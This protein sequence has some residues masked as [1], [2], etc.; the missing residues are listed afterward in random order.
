[1]TLLTEVMQR[2]LDPG[3]AQAARRRAAGEPRP[4][5]A[6]T[7]VVALACGVIVSIAV[8]Q[9]RAP[10]PEMVRAR[11]G[12][13]KEIQQR[14]DHVDS[15]MHANQTLRA[16]IS[17]AQQ[18]AL[19]GGQDGA[20]AGQ[21]RQ[22]E[23]ISGEIPLTGPGLQITVDDAPNSRT[24]A[25]LDPRQTASSDQGR[26]LDRDLQVVVNGLWASGAE[27]ISVNGQ[28]LTALSAIRSAG[29]AILVDFRPLVPPYVVQAIGDANTMQARFAADMAGPY[30]QSL[31]DNYGIQ[32]NITP[33]SSLTLPGADSLAL[34][35]ARVP[36][37]TPGP[38]PHPSGR[39]PGTKTPGGRQPVTT[40]P[41]SPGGTP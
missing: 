11:A 13:E 29:K 14:T 28:R 16:E 9:L 31:Q 36:A 25:G 37:A 35:Q 32:A 12:L 5:A 24:A 27:A 15:L 8:L 3:Y 6:L 19:G 20:L 10:Q 21:M 30:L 38:T 1:M 4:A 34:R 18:A 26:V 41:A 23:L 33:K 39:S 2:P 17:T 22:L 7:V 40:T